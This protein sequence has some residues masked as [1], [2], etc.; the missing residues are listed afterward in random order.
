MQF[1]KI[2]ILPPQKGLEFPWGGG[3]GF[4]K[5]KNLKAQ[6]KLDAKVLALKLW[7]V[8]VGNSINS[9]LSPVMSPTILCTLLPIIG[10]QVATGNG[11]SSLKN[12]MT[13]LLSPLTQLII[14]V[15]NNNKTIITVVLALWLSVWPSGFKVQIMLSSQATGCVSS[16]GVCYHDNFS[17]MWRSW[18]PGAGLSLPSTALDLID[19]NISIVV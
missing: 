1:Q 2:S 3:V 19:K 16:V 18:M 12:L 14:I 9:P 10:Q 15:W 6:R 13:K 4:C 17:Q 11:A 8:S 5:A 7:F